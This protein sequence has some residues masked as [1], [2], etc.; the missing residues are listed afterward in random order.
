MV[1]LSDFL[2]VGEA[3]EH[4]AVSADSLGRWGWAGRLKA[5][6][7]PITRFWLY[8]GSDLDEFVNGLLDQKAVGRRPTKGQRTRAR[9]GTG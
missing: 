6:R 7:H 5:R 3:V 1:G 4:L 8:L 9:R 2:T